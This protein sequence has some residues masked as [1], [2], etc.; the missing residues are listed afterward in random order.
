MKMAMSRGILCRFCRYILHGWQPSRTLHVSLRSLSVWW[1]KNG[2]FSWVQLLQK[3]SSFSKVYHKLCRAARSN[4]TSFCLERF[5]TY[6]PQAEVIH[7]FRAWRPCRIKV[8]SDKM[9]ADPQIQLEN[10]SKTRKKTACLDQLITTNVL[11]L[12]GCFKSW[13]GNLVFVTSSCQSLR[14][15]L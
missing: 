12:E 6:R 15:G 10:V 11:W 1:M 5:R 3:V 7:L 14:L 8:R 4:E 9:T 13:I 2:P